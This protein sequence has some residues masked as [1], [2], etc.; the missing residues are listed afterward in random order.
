MWPI[1]TPTEVQDEDE[2]CDRAFGSV[3]I[4]ISG[5]PLRCAAKLPQ[6]QHSYPNARDSLCQAKKAWAN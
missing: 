5:T 6:P 2:E 3:I 4:T 1:A